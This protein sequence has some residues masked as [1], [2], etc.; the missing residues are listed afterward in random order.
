[1]YLSRK[2]ELLLLQRHDASMDMPRL[3]IVLEIAINKPWSCRAPFLQW[4]QSQPHR[5]PQS[6]AIGNVD[7]VIPGINRHH[8]EDI[9]AHHGSTVPV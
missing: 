7:R 4:S 5:L 1:M 2:S 6:A 8:G 9:Q 3:R